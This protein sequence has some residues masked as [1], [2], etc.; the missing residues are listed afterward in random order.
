M[1]ALHPRLKRESASSTT[2]GT[3]VTGAGF[4][5]TP[6]SPSLITVQSLAKWPGGDEE[7]EE[8]EEEEGKKEEGEDG[9][10]G[11]GRGARDGGKGEEEE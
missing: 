10:R 3:Y 8:E 1:P 6:G 2:S 4:P 5:S 9:E 11:G 7:E